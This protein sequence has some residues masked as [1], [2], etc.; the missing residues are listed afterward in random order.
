MLTTKQTGSFNI[1]R[2]IDRLELSEAIKWLIWVVVI[3]ASLFG[4]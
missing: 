3:L 4:P 1:D 2:I